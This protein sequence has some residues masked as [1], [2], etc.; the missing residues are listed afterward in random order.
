M[1]LRFVQYVCV[2]HTF[3]SRQHDL[4]AEDKAVA[5][6]PILEKETKLHFEVP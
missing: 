3:L 6:M 5:G 4:S 2:P 1:V